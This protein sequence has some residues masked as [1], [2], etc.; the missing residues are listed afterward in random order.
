MWIGLHEQANT[1]RTKTAQ[2]TL[3]LDVSGFK[4]ISSRSRKKTKSSGRL[5]ESLK[6]FVEG[7][8]KLCTKSVGKMN[9]LSGLIGWTTS[10]GESV[11]RMNS[12]IGFRDG[13]VIAS[14]AGQ[15]PKSKKGNG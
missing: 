10:P 9:C 4:S 2:P 6:L 7:T 14:G 12:E 11:K 1:L 8:M 5:V 13:P 3:S 15:E